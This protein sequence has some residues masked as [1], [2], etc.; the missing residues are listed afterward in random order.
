MKLREE[1]LNA[2]ESTYANDNN[3]VVDRIIRDV[4][5]WALK[6]V[7]KDIKWTK[8]E[9]LKFSTDLNHAKFFEM[10]TNQEK[11]AIRQHIEESD[12]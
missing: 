11:N 8:K 2:V 1:I 12:N 9:A 10:T 5:Q 3:E 6:M 7:G 4:K